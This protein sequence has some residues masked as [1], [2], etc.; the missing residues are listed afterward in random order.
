M[1]SYIATFRLLNA[2][3]N[4]NDIETMWISAYN[5]RHAIEKA[6]FYAK[7]YNTSLINV[8]AVN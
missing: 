1:K 8:R 5:M 2:A 6:R 3:F 4:T 7:E